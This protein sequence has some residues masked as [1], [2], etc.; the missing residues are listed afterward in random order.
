KDLPLAIR[1]R[2]EGRIWRTKALGVEIAG[3]P[4]F[5]GVFI[6]GGNVL[7]VGRQIRHKLF[8]GCLTPGVLSFSSRRVL[9]PGLRASNNL[10][11][12]NV[13]PLV[14]ELVCIV[15]VAAHPTDQLQTLVEVLAVVNAV[16]TAL[17][18]ILLNIQVAIAHD[19]VPID[20]VIA[21]IEVN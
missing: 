21:A 18:N 8:I 19:I 5:D 17:P 16:D 12:G 13:D 4:A 10:F 15:G 20:A 9:S 6:E 14:N 11:I 1:N 3:I 2:A 7:V